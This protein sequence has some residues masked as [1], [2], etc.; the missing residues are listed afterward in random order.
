MWTGLTDKNAQGNPEEQKRLIADR[1]TRWA[2]SDGGDAVQAAAAI[3]AI[4]ETY[5][6]GR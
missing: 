3:W 4:L 5:L 1:L 2:T 6:P